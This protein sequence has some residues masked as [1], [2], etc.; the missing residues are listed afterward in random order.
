MGVPRE[1]IQLV[2]RPDGVAAGT[3]RVRLLGVKSR[4]DWTERMRDYTRRRLDAL[5]ALNLCGYVLKRDSPTCGME[6]VRV[7]HEPGATR[8][9]RGL[10]AESLLHAFPNLPVEEEGR[11]HDPRLRENFVERVF[12]YQRVRRLFG[13]RWTRGAL[14]EF[15]TAHKLQLLAHSRKGYTEL[16][17]LVAAAA[18]ID[19]RELA[20]RYERDFMQ[21]LARVSTP[22][23]HA[24]VMLHMLGHL[25]RSIDAADRDE[26]IASIDDHRRGL[27]PIVVPMTLIRHHVRR[28]GIEYLLRQVYLDPHPRELS[29]RNHV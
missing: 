10:F 4:A 5:A 25:K 19:R 3:E 12:A 7:Y 11:L 21:T 1:A 22:G 9:G 27:L 24:D 18:S 8:T 14:V 26:L 13:G 28:H 15:H 6:R 23:R 29:L 16:G 2:A 17:R 20:D